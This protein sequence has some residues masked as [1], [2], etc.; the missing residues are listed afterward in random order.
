MLAPLRDRGCR[1]AL[2]NGCFDV[3]HVG[4]VRLLREAAGAAD[5]LVVA[6][7]ADASVRRNKGEGRPWVPLDERMEVV[8]A[9]EGVAYVTSF[10]EPTAHAL[11]DSIRPDV[12]VKGTDWTAETV[13]ERE[14]V[15]AYGGRILIAGD[16][17]THSSTGLIGKLRPS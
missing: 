9:L 6:L 10:D 4:H 1:V 11:L 8:A 16:P 15:E 7:N 13:P 2:A 14:V 3:L 17:K 5:L 12:H